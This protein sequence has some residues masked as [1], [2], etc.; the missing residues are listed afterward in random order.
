MTNE[1]D[2][3]VEY[4]EQQYERSRYGMMANPSDGGFISLIDDHAGGCSCEQ[5][6]TRFSFSKSAAYMGSG[7]ERTRYQMRNSYG[8]SDIEFDNPPRWI[9]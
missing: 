4:L 1:T 7:D 5:E 9:A 2:A 8:V 3:A 6:G